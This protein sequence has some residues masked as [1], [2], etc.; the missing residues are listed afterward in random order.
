MDTGTHRHSDTQT[1]RH[2][3]TRTRG[4]R[5]IGT[6]GQK[7]TRTQGHTPCGRPA[8]LQGAAGGDSALLRRLPWLCPLQDFPIFSPSETLRATNP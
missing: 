7:D 5:D 3:D 6:Q 8:A 1:H 2:T 4:H